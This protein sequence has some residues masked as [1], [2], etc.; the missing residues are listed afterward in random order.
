M[1]SPAHNGKAQTTRDDILKPKADVSGEESA[2][3]EQAQLLAA[4]ITYV[5]Q[6]FLEKTR[7]ITGD[8]NTVQ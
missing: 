1:T 2:P 7:A 6:A 8:S 3:K 4:T 5:G